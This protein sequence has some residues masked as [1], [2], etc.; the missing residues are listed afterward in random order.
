MSAGET[1]RQTQRL[2]KWLWHARIIKTRSLA[3]QLIEK[4]KFQINREKIFKPA[5]PVKCGDV[6]T[7]S[8]S[9]RI[10]ILQIAGFSERRGPA[11]E[12]CRLY[13]DVT[14]GQDKPA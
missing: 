13:V 1:V 6:I 8:H 5:F 11:T 10:R 3:A 12:A 14:P 7:A 4:G 9:G 2:D